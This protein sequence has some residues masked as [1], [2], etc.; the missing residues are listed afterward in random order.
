M[1][2]VEATQQAWNEGKGPKTVNTE[3]FLNSLDRKSKSFS[4]CC[5]FYLFVDFL[6]FS[7]FC[8]F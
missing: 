8:S 5:G 2:S 1:N 4:F 7:P 6:L 3:I